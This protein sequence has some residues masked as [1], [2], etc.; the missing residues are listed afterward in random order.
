V[1]HTVTQSSPSSR[2]SEASRF[3]VRQATNLRLFFSSSPS[4]SECS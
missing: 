1:L 3:R 2:E 4:R